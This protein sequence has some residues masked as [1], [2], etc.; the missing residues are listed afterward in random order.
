MTLN[1]ILM[2]LIIVGVG[3][4]MFRKKGGSGDGRKK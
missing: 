4:W 2:L 1:N 3:Y